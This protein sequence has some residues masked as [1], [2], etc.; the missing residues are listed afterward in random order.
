MNICADPDEP[1]KL[2]EDRPNSAEL[3]PMTEIQFAIGCHLNSEYAA[4]PK[5][6]T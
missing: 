2:V 4:L 1:S 5:E 6:V 3:A